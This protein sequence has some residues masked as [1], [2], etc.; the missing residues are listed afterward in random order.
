MQIIKN[1]KVLVSLILFSFCIIELSKAGTRDPSVLDSEYL[2]YAKDFKYV[3][4]LKGRYKD[5]ST[6]IASAVAIDNHHILTAAHIIQ[7]TRYKSC[8]F[9]LDEKIFPITVFKKPKE[10]TM[11][12]YGKFDIALGYSLKPFNL[13]FYPELYDGDDEVGKVCCISGFGYTGTFT[14]GAV[15]QDYQLRAGSNVIDKTYNDLLICSP[16]KEDSPT[17]TS[18]EFLISIGDS[19]GGLFIDGKLAGINS[20]V[21][22]NGNSPNSSYDDESG[23]TRV[24]QF[25]DWIEKNKIK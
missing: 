2:T 20:C 15:T 24:S 17:R 4:K 25:L 21:L 10:F 8:V 7:N 16:S 22:T 23:H 14:T 1:M 12:Q 5:G 19:G 3:G 9:I 18:L 11:E 13:S 6:F